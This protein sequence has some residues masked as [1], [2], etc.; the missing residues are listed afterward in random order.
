MALV[1]DINEE[2]QPEGAQTIVADEPANQGVG[3]ESLNYMAPASLDSQYTPP[4]PD[5]PS[6]SAGAGGFSLAGAGGSST[7]MR[8]KL[9]A[10]GMRYIGQPYSWGNLDCSGLVQRA[11]AAIGIKMPR[12]SYQQ[13]NSGKRENIGS[14]SPGDL[15]A[16][17][18]GPRNPGADH[19][20]IYIGNGQIL[21]AAHTGTDVR[22]RKLGKD[23]GAWGVHINVSGD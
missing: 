14:L 16:W 4:Q 2:Q 13:A 18:E 20:A 6:T 21:E 22:V 12:I 15:V 9:I 19:I 3:P 17:D 7:A 1:P 10:A 8:D 5:A 11:Y 23:E